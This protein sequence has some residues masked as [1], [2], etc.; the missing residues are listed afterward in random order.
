[1]CQPAPA[2]AWPWT[3][4]TCCSPSWSS[5][6]ASEHPEINVITQHTHTYRHT[7]HHTHPHT[8]QHTDTHTHTHTHTHTERQRKKS[9]ILKVNQRDSIHNFTTHNA[10]TFDIIIITTDTFT[11][12]VWS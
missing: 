1:M 7:T 9:V 12:A 3:R 5:W 8:T 4:I 6:T 2:A 11:Q 10:L